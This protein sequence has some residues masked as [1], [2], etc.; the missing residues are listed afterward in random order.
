MSRLGQHPRLRLD[1]LRRQH[2]AAVRHRGIEA[3]AL[4]V[5]GELLDRV[6][7]P[8]ALDL[9]RDPAV[10]LVAAHEIDRADV[11]RPLSAHK[12]KALPAP[13]G[14]A[15]QRLLQVG[16]DAVLL[17]RRRLAHVALDVGQD[18]GD[19]DVQPVLSGPRAFAHDDPIGLLLDHRGR[20]HP[21]MVLDGG[22]RQPASQALTAKAIG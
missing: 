10:V 13:L 21:A 19:A 3:D 4:E 18:L 17:E 1:D 16:L 6:D 7:R 9:D 2:A 20:R 14:R 15:G 22:P 8:H 11:R 12:P 5:T